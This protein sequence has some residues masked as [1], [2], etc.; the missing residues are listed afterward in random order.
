M[1]DTATASSEARSQTGGRAPSY[2]AGALYGLAAVVIWASWMAITRLGVTTSLDALDII[3]L[4]FGTAG[5][6][7]LPVLLRLG[8]PGRRTGWW[9]LALLVGCGGAPYGLLATT[10]LRFAPAAHGGILIP[11]VMPLMVAL[12]SAVALRERFSRG[13]KLGYA[14]IL[15]GVALVAGAPAMLLDSSSALGHVLLLSAAFLWACYTVVLRQTDLGALHATAIVAVGSALLVLPFY[16]LTRPLGT[17]PAPPLELAFQALYQ[18]VIATIVS[19]YVFAKAVET[20]GASAGA[21]FGAL[22]PALAALLAIPILGELPSPQDWLGILAVTLGVYLASGGPLPWRRR[23][24][25]R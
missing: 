10:G 8:V 12:I 23:A 20:L 22:V 9:R 19:F 13:R 17:L 2:L 16:L 7:L 15:A 11:G 21:A 4:R 5:L 24:G 6:L 3:T 1:V 25:Q 14:L 18:G